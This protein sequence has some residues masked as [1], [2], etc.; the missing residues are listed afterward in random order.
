[1]G[2]TRWFWSRFG[3]M[4]EGADAAICDG[5][6]VSESDHDAAIAE[7]NKEI[8]RLTAER[9]VAVARAERADKELRYH[10]TQHQ[11]VT[12]SLQAIMAQREELKN[13]LDNL[14]HRCER[15]EEALSEIERAIFLNP[16]LTIAHAQAVFDAVGQRIN[17]VFI[18]ATQDANGK[19]V[20]MPAEQPEYLCDICKYDHSGRCFA[21]IDVDYCVKSLATE[22]REAVAAKER[23]EGALRSFVSVMDKAGDDGPC[24]TDLEAVAHEARGLLAT[25]QEA[26]S[27]TIPR[28]EAAEAV[29]MAVMKWGKIHMDTNTHMVECDSGPLNKC[30]PCNCFMGL[31]QAYVRKYQGKEVLVIDS[32]GTNGGPSPN[33]I[34]DVQTLQ[35]EKEEGK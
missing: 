18:A 16:V 34:Q 10:E 17:K 6:Y 25:A 21:L 9:D 35:R 23:A 5:D 20:I 28:L 22:R 8:D 14:T 3:M 12:K 33:S 13:N 31:A 26:K 19:E 24:I 7:K 4:F 29:V 1:M 2:T 32:L 30:G 11:S 27:A 15:A